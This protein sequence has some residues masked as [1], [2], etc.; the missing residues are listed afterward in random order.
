MCIRDRGEGVGLAPEAEGGA[1]RNNSEKSDR[2]VSVTLSWR[3]VWPGLM[4]PGDAVGPVSYTHLDVY[5]R[6]ALAAAVAAYDWQHMAPLYDRA[7]FEEL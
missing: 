7:L 2:A 1:S 4:G 3:G 5:K 6:Q